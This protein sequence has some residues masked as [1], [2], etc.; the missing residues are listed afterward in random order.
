M[1]FNNNNY[2][3]YQWKNEAIIIEVIFCYRSI[4]NDFNVFLCI[5]HYIG[6]K[7]TLITQPE[8]SKPS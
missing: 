6:L 8:M 1:I 2:C 3:Q 4:H 5:I 7:V